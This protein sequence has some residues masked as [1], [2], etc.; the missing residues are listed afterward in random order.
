M[1]HLH[2]VNLIIHQNYNNSPWVFIILSVAILSCD[3]LCQRY[4][5]FFAKRLHF[6]PL[7]RDLP[8]PISNPLVPLKACKHCLQETFE[9]DRPQ[10]HP[11]LRSSVE[12][13]ACP[14]RLLKASSIFGSAVFHPLN[15]DNALCPRAYGWI[16]HPFFTQLCLGCP[17]LK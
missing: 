17:Q 5:T 9:S 11:L 6:K 3:I 16:D 1:V 13:I 2:Q 8:V 7:P 10:G 4:E 14:E 12:N 15:Q